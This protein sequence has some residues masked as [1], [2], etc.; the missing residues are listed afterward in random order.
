[1]KMLVDGKPF[2]TPIYD[3]MRRKRL[4]STDKVETCD[5]LLVE[6]RLLLTDHELRDMITISIYLDTDLDIMLSRRVF[7][8]IARGANIEDIT[9]RY[10]KYVKPAHEKLIEP[11]RENC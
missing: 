9:N 7:K 4:L 5:V 6:G 10:L 1:M 11:V 3:L 8:G 2:N